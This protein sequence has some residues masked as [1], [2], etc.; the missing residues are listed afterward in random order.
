VCGGDLSDGGGAEGGE[1]KER[2][3]GLFH[4]EHSIDG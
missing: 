4:G 3:C 1:Q 2:R